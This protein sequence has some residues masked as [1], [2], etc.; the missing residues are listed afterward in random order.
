MV[1]SL[2]RGYSSVVFPERRG[3]ASPLPEGKRSGVRLEARRTALADTAQIIQP[4]GA[5]LEPR[6]VCPRW[7]ALPRVPPWAVASRRLSEWEPTPWGEGA[8]G[9]RYRRKPPTM[10]H[11]PKEGATDYAYIWVGQRGDLAQDTQASS[12]N[13]GE[14]SGEE[15]PRGKR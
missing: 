4:L 6:C 15:R 11:K 8:S 10:R 1:A 13:Y 3:A 5:T 14:G 2:L 12:A 9:Y 7:A